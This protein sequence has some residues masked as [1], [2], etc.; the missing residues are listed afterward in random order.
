MK[1][2]R[3]FIVSLAAFCIVVGSFWYWLGFQPVISKVTPASASFGEPITITGMYLGDSP[4]QLLLD[5]IPLPRSAISAWN[6]ERII[7]SFLTRSISQ[8]F[9]CAQIS[10]YQTPT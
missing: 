8:Q 9:V 10:V 2:R 1:K 7:F 6:S 4:G 5:G 3:V